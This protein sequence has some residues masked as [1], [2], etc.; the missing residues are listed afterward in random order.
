MRHQEEVEVALRA[1]SLLAAREDV[2]E[3]GLLLP[4]ESGWLCRVPNLV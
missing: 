2:A 4:S 3:D 1:V